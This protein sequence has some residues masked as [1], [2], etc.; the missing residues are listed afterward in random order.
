MMDLNQNML[1][2]IVILSVI[3]AGAVAGLLLLKY[4]LDSRSQAT[5]IACRGKTTVTCVIRPQRNTNLD[6]YLFDVQVIETSTGLNVT[7][8]SINSTEGTPTA[9]GSRNVPISFEAGAGDYICR[10]TARPKLGQ[11]CPD[12][13]SAATIQ[14]GT[15][16]CRPPNDERPTPTPKIPTDEPTETPPGDGG[17][18]KTPPSP[19]PGGCFI[20]NPEIKFE[21]RDCVPTP[22][23]NPNIDGEGGCGV[24]PIDQ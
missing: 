19:T 11:Y 6:D 4:S 9:D 8:G 16:V 1:K 17:L 7:T 12:Q 18:T 2:K 14:S 13:E 3:G 24:I 22:T 23:C 10:V 20:I 21:C 5:Q 15:K